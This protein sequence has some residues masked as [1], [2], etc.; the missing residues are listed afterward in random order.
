[1]AR[2]GKDKVTHATSQA[3]RDSEPLPAE[4]VELQQALAVARERE[5]ALQSEVDSLKAVLSE[6]REHLRDWEEYFRDRHDQ[7][8]TALASPKNVVVQTG[9][10]P[11]VSR[12]TDNTKNFKSGDITNANVNICFG[13]IKDSVVKSFAQM[14]VQADETA[15]KLK[16]LLEKLTELLSEATGQGVDEQV[17]AEALEQVKVIADAAQKRDEGGF[18]PTV[19]K[20]LRTL[21]GFSEDLK[22]VPEIATQ[23]MG[24]VNAIAALLSG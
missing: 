23:Y 10:R 8:M 22:S 20:T 24:Y 3:H 1:M 17:A 15:A 13:D 18:L 16:P 5:N 11:E 14:P 6:L 4:Y 12:M 9:N 2:D 21:R 19:R 7:A